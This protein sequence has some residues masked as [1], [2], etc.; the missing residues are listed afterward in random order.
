MLSSLYFSDLSSLPVQLGVS[1]FLEISP[2]LQV[3]QVFFRVLPVVSLE[4][5]SEVE[6]ILFA[7]FLK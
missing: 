2:G 1:R 7:Y 3:C 4:K 6:T 5:I